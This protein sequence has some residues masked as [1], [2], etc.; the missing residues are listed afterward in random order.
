MSEPQII[1][2]VAG[3]EV[4]REALRQMASR[5]RWILAAD[6]GAAHL[7][8]IQVIPH[9]VIGDLDSMD[10]ETRAWLEETGVLMECHPVDKDATDLELA[11]ERAREL[12]GSI[13]VFGA[14][15][16]RLDQT[17]ASLLLLAHPRWVGWDVRF[18]DANREAFVLQG[19]GWIEGKP[20]DRVSLIPLTSDV[21]GV[22]LEGLFYPLQEGVLPFG[23]TLG[24]SN[25][26]VAPR[27]RIR[28][29]RGLLLVIH[30]RGEPG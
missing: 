16:S 15:G 10:P 5:A 19:E 27:A 17:V 14:W 28:A 6:G 2:I 22:T 29:R 13:R 8:A 12:G 3:G 4:D 9:Q 7:R 20:G 18:M 30:E 1:L 25:R 23:S 11:M 24:I 21:E 26:M